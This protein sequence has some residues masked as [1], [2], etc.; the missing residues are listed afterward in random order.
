MDD[1]DLKIAITKNKFSGFKGIV[2]MKFY[3]SSSRVEEMDL[4]FETKKN[5]GSLF[6]QDKKGEEELF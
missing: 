4:P 2:P 3:R 5:E 1:L 6:G